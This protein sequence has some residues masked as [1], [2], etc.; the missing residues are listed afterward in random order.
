FFAISTVLS[1]LDV[2]ACYRVVL[3]QDQSV[4]VVAPVLPG[5]VPIPGTRA[6]AQGDLRPDLS[7]CARHQIRSPRSRIRAIAA[8]IPILSI[9]LIARADRVSVTLRRSEGAG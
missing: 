6:R 9:V 8:S 4:R 7:S 3:A 5:H 1:K 2:P